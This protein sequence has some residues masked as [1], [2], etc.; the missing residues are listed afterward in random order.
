VDAAWPHVAA[1]LTSRATGKDL[2]LAAIE[3]STSIR[4]HEAIPLLNDLAESEDEDIVA[5]VDEAIVMADGL[6]ADEEDNDLDEDE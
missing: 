3:A 6:S 2:L 1:L 4:P 5:A